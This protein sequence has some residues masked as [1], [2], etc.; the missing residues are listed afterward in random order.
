MTN[1][2]SDAFSPPSWTHQLRRLSVRDDWIQFLARS[3]LIWEASQTVLNGIENKN[4]K[5]EVRAVQRWTGI[6]I[7]STAFQDE[8][9]ERALEVAGFGGRGGETEH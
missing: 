5:A 2:A 3:S 6:H 9:K 1:C 4:H 8:G 7:P